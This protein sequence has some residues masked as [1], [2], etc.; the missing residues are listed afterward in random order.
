M[1]ERGDD[2][3]EFRKGNEEE[4]GDEEEMKAQQEERRP[5]GRLPVPSRKL[6]E[7]TG[8]RE[9][10]GRGSSMGTLSARPRSLSARPGASSQKIF[11]PGL[12]RSKRRSRCWAR[13]DAG[14]KAAHPDL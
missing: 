6:S 4:L 11:E 14:I 8:L 3:H 12:R 10:G 2:G 9:S 7:R 5:K 1:D 13:R